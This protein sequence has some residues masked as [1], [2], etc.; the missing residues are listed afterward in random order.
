MSGIRLASR[1]ILL[2]GFATTEHGLV[3]K[4]V[5]RVGDA[6]NAQVTALDGRISDW[7]A[8]DDTYQFMVDHDHG[9]IDTNLPEGSTATLAGSPGS[10]RST[11]WSRRSTRGP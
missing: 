1:V 8:W 4:D 6:I 5:G 9:C 3:V 7:A 2:D 10:R 11:C